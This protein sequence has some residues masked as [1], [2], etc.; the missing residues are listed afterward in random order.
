MVLA[1]YLDNPEEQVIATQKFR[2]LLSKEPNPPIDAVIQSGIVPKFIEFL[3]NHKNPTLQVI[4]TTFTNVLANC[5]NFD[6]IIV[7]I[8]KCLIR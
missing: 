2:K 3:T 7:Y 8:I 4:Y 1:V 6:C 5:W